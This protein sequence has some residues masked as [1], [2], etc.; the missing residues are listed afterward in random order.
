MAKKNHL[1]ARKLPVPII[2]ELKKTL[3][4]R[5]FKLVEAV[6]WLE[7]LFNTNP[8]NNKTYYQRIY[9]LG[10]GELQEPTQQEI[11]AI[12]YLIYCLNNPHLIAQG[13]SNLHPADKKIKAIESAINSGYYNR[14]TLKKYLNTLKKSLPTI[15]I[16]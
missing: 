3:D 11:Q 5:G 7:D 1:Q 8:D 10:T 15:S 2:D 9:K 4:K 13:L 6:N 14:A 16:H 12:T